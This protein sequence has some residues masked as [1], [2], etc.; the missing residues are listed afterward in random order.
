MLRSAMHAHDALDRLLGSLNVSVQ[1]FSAAR[2][3]EVLLLQAAPPPAM[4]VVALLDGDCQLSLPG[5]CERQCRPGMMVLIPA[6]IPA[7]LQAV[8]SDFVRIAAGIVDVRLANTGL[9]DRARVP[10]F[11]DLTRW[12]FVRSALDEAVRL[13]PGRLKKLGSQALSDSLMKTC[14]LVVLRDFFQRPGIDH[15]IVAA[16]TNPRLGAVVAAILHRPQLPHSLESMAGLAGLGRSA[17]SRQFSEAMGLS[18]IDFLVKTR[19]FHGAE[20]LRL[21][22]SPVKS[23]AA[24]VGFASRSHFSR[25]FREHFGVD[26][27]AY[28][29]ER[30][31]LPPPVPQ[32]LREISM[33]RTESDVPN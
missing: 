22:D 18:P 1:G 17:F 31:P 32:D 23:V 20:L 30:Q 10:I 24:R 15:K 26:P 8:G 33:R 4:L 6:G 25:A 3:E 21:T 7:S 12:T 5:L 29:R 27:S 19:L 9:L 11:T 16:L 13:D 2:F 14:I 28:R